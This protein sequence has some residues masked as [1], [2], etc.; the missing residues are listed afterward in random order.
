[1]WGAGIAFVVDVLVSVAVTFRT[2]PKPEHELAGLVHGVR[3]A[4]FH[5]DSLAGDKAW[6]RS[7][8]PLGLGA[9]ALGIALYLPLI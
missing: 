3:P 5:D 6:Y 8:I 2:T 9:L 7:P 4:E 1:F